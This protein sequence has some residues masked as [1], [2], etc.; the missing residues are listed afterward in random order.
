[1]RAEESNTSA[2]RDA[3]AR[4]LVV[5]RE[6]GAWGLL[7]VPFV[8]GA[9]ASWGSGQPWWLELSLLVCALSLFWLRTPLE[10]LLGSGPIKAQTAPERRSAL[11]AALLIFCLA[12][13][14]LAVLMWGGS[15]SGLWKLG[16]VGGLA[17]L[18]QMLLRRLGR[19]TRLA[20]QLVGAIGLT[21]TAPAAYYVGS[22]RLD[23]RALALWAAN[24]L[25]AANQIHFVQ[26]RIHA[27]RAGTFPEKI[28]VGK[29]FLAMQVLVLAAI[30]LAT[31]WFALPSL[32]VLAFL[33]VLFRGTRWFFLE[34]APLDVKRLGRSELN[35]GIAFGLLLAL[36]FLWK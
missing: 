3:R 13:A 1:M 19:G 2:A 31:R 7:L 16:A 28:R 30:A 25:F 11:L 26:L 34:A 12:I 15:N 23:A 22:G 6:H 24:W 21:A 32:I 18:L 5:P 8:S 4:A 10:S 29:V 20:S 9:L 36:A 17:F 35:H 14:S 27:A 33:P